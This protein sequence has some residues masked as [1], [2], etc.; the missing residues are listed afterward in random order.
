MVQ[1]VY[2][3]WKKPGLVVVDMRHT[4]LGPG[5]C[6]V[7]AESACRAPSAQMTHQSPVQ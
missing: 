2:C 5:D 7:D 3:P 6:M 1:V 4:V